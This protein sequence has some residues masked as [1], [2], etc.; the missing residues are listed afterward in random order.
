MT[1]TGTDIIHTI[2]YRLYPEGSEEISGVWT[3]DGSN[4]IMIPEGTSINTIKSTY[5]PQEIE[6]YIKAGNE[7][8]EVN[9]NCYEDLDKPLPTANEVGNKYL[10]IGRYNY[11]GELSLPSTIINPWEFKPDIS[12]EFHP[13]D[14]PDYDREISSDGYMYSVWYE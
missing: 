9:V 13:I 4:P 5:L 12:V 2:K 10:F 7:T 3:D 11:I 8:I 14:Y 1:D 6:A